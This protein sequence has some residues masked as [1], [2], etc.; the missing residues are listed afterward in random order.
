M[1]SE[2]VASAPPSIGKS[3]SWSIAR[4]SDAALKQKANDANK[5]LM[6]AIVAVPDGFV[7]Q[8]AIENR[9]EAVVDVFLRHRR[10]AK[11]SAYKLNNLPSYFFDEIA[12]G[13]AF[14]TTISSNGLL[15]NLLAIKMRS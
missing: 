4:E 12:S 15:K 10:T 13:R 11:Q 2:Q 7:I 6:L 5:L 8:G 9:D 14:V 3:L 1:N